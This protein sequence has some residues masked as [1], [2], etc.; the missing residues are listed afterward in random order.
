LHAPE[1]GAFSLQ[2]STSNVLRPRVGRQR[3]C[4]LAPP[5]HQCTALGRAADEMKHLRDGIYG[6]ESLSAIQQA[7]N[8]AWSVVGRN[9]VQANMELARS[10]LATCLLSIADDNIRDVKWLTQEALKAMA[11]NYHSSHSRRTAARRSDPQ[12]GEVKVPENVIQRA[13]ELARSGEIR[14]LQGI[15]R[16]LRD[17]GYVVTRHFDG[18][19][20]RHQLKKLMAE[21]PELETPKDGP[22]R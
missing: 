20:M 16:R 19:S 2:N 6:P 5:F 9:Y 8:Q 4:G 7:F 11:L 14:T 3:N 13:F 17:E 18:L 21:A 1:P 15:L 10:R 12:D 22:G